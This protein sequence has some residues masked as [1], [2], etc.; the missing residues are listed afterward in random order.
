G[1]AAQKPPEVF[2]IVREVTQSISSSQDSQ[3]PVSRAGHARKSDRDDSEEHR[4]HRALPCRLTS[5][6]GTS[7]DSPESLDPERSALRWK[8]NGSAEDHGLHPRTTGE[9]FRRA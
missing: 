5:P 4:T 3:R 1:T 2:G 8:S 9:V 6:Y 7:P